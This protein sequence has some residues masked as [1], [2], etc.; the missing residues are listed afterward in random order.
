[1]EPGYKVPSRPTITAECRRL[2]DSM[3]G[4]LLEDVHLRHVAFT[5]DI[6]TS[7]ATES[8]VTFTV[9]W[10]NDEWEL[11]NKVLFTKEFPERHTADNIADYLHQACAEWNIPDDHVTAIVHNNASNMT[12]AVRKLQW[13]SLLCVV[14]NFPL[15]KIW[16]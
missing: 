14:C 5:T 7:R 12:S 10:I 4:K 3:K 8:Y 16:D 9:H 2:Y 6:W 13:E 1:M 15:T 11:E